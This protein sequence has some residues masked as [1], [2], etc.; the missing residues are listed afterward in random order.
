MIN[1]RRS[2]GAPE[3]RQ[4]S[5]VTRV[6]D[7]VTRVPHV[8]RQSVMTS[9]VIAEIARVV[10]VVVMREPDSA[11][12]SGVLRVLAYWYMARDCCAT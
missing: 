4:P 5:R 10:V 6:R 3:R 9:R 8:R 12:Q 2:Q 11:E 7:L 1:S